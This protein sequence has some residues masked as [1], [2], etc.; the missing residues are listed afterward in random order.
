MS[1][2]ALQPSRLSYELVVQTPIGERGLVTDLMYKNCE[3][4]VGERK[5]VVDLISLPI[6]G[7][8]VIL[9]MDCLS[10]Y[11]AQMNC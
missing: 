6:R 11:N 5:L 1:N 2:L 4:W 9:G 7:Y 10:R 3:I 8:D